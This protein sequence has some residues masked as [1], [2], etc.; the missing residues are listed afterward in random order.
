MLLD[1]RLTAAG[2]HS[3]SRSSG[4]Y[5]L[6]CSETAGRPV[7]HWNTQPGRW[8]Y[9]H[10]SLTT[11]GLQ[12]R[13]RSSKDEN[14]AIIYQPSTLFQCCMRCFFFFFF[15][16]WNTKREILTKLFSHTIAVTH[17]HTNKIKHHKSSSNDSYTIYFI[18]LLKIAFCSIEKNVSEVDKL[19]VCI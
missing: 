6:Q 2:C 18:S 8:S 10:M 16:L 19:H 11:A 17:T 15:F 3:N 4:R 7:Y 1:G 5:T 14:A 12:A 13:N 9:Q